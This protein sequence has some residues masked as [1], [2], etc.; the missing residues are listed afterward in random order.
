MGATIHGFTSWSSVAESAR[1]T[2]DHVAESWLLCHLLSTTPSVVDNLFSRL[3][4]RSTVD[5][6]SS[7]YIHWGAHQ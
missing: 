4:S 2:G 1:P 5:G 3:P 6:G 7:A